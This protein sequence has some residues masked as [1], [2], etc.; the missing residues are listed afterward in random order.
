MLLSVADYSNHER[1]DQIPLAVLGYVQA[2]VQLR[3][4]IVH[5]RRHQAGNQRDAGDSQR[6]S[7][8][9]DR[10]YPEFAHYSVIQRRG[11]FRI[12]ALRPGQPDN[13]A[14]DLRNLSP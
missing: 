2:D 5:R 1:R 10:V 4:R 6:D 9:N 11:V 8:G 3:R 14:P 7:D 13:Y 12:S